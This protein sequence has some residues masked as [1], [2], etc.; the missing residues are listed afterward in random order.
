MNELKA[1]VTITGKV[2]SPKVEIR[3]DFDPPLNPKE[4]DEWIGS[5]ALSMVLPFIQRLKEED[6]LRM[7]MLQK[8]E[9]PP[10][11]EGN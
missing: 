4:P 2:K 10:V 8:M 11:S 3:I 1:V 6:K 5:G 7:A 9:T